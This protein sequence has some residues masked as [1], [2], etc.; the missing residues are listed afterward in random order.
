MA[1]AASRD[2][3]EFVFEWEGKD[4]N[5]KQV[6]GETRA[7]GENQ[8]KA[9]LRRQG[10]LATKIKKRSMRSGKSIKPRDIAIF[11]RQLATMM[12]AGVPLLQAFDI[13]GR[14]NANAS[15]T[16]LL[17]DVRTDVETGT[18]LSA[19]FR[20]Y[21]LYFN[22]LYCNLVEAGEAAGILE[23]LLDRLAVYMEKTEAIK[24]KIKSALMYPTS[25]VVV[26]FV[27]VAVI[28]I[29]VIPAFKE[30]F[31][32]FGAD[33]PAP[34]LFVMAISEFFVAYWWLIF[35]SVGGG[36]Y[37]FMQA[38][39]RNEKVQRFMDRLLLKMPVFG[40]LIEKSC[41]ARWTRTLSTMFAAGVPLVEAL[42]SVGG[43]SGN[44]LYEDAT[45]KIQQ[46]VSTGT[47]L[48]AAM[49]NANLFPTMVLQMCAIGEESG[50]V[51]HMLGKAADFYEAEV[52]EMVAGLSSLMEP[53]IIVFLGGLIGGIVVSMYL[54]IFKLGQVV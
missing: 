36:I 2:I 22:A 14:G 46:E 41:I 15:V 27:V 20:K 32:S 52:D 29:F 4:R 48:T 34:T 39:K 40:A 16:K 9:S 1:T 6:R 45:R 7:V 43:A 8:V 24:S 17:N 51:D 13:V 38:W 5:G 33:L 44:S 11:T 54:P 19:A 49:G 3:K 26:A 23:Q 42:D 10:V 37:F 18:S 30:V 21:P 12:K 31:S 53:I 50:S 35:G 28:M 25:V 47:S